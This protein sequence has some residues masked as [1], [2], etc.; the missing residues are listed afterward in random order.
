MKRQTKQKIEADEVE[1]S[2]HFGLYTKPLLNMVENG[3]R[4]ECKQDVVD[5]LTEVMLGYIS[6]RRASDILFPEFGPLTQR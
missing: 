1:V 2:T 5:V 3:W 4:P 6:C